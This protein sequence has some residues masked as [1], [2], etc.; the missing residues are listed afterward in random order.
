MIDAPPLPDRLATRGRFNGTAKEAIVYGARKPEAIVALLLLC[1]GDKKR[2]QRE[3]LLDKDLTVG[4]MGLAE[5]EQH[6]SVATGALVV[7]VVEGASR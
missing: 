1:D 3:F 4:G 6:G 5:H 2:Q 7:V